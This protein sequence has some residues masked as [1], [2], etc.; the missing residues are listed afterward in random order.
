LKLEDSIKEQL[1]HYATMYHE[2]PN[3]VIRSKIE[4]AVNEYIKENAKNIFVRR[5]YKQYYEVVRDR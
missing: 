4:S 1:D 5:E 3:P 2:Y